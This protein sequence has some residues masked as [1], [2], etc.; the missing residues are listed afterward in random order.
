[1]H[2]VLHH[3]LQVSVV[4][5]YSDW[6]WCLSH[7]SNQWSRCSGTNEVRPGTPL[8]CRLPNWA[9][10]GQSARGPPGLPLDRPF[11][12]KTLDSKPVKRVSCAPHSN[13]NG[14]NASVCAGSDLLGIFQILYLENFVKSCDSLWGPF[15][16]PWCELNTCIGGFR[17]SPTITC[18]ARVT[19]DRLKSRLM[20]PA[21]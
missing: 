17:R 16:S 10:W 7:N 2:T 21:F 13:L 19:S 8:S 6:E 4:Y 20:S 3:K 5:S 18:F 11:K 14:L 1:M 12:L 9:P 15:H